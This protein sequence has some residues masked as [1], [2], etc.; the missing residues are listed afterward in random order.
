MKV[1]T[2]ASPDKISLNMFV[3]FLVICLNKEYVLGNVHS[4]MTED[5][6]ENYALGFLERNPKAIFCYY[7]KKKINQSPQKVIPKKL[8]EISDAVVW[9]DLYATKFTLVKDECK[10]AEAFTDSWGKHLEKLNLMNTGGN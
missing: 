9:F 7:A 3:N 1:I 8:T 5:S 2:V 10:F 4:L 6:V